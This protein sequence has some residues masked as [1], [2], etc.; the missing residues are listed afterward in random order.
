MR[1]G[2]EGCRCQIE[3]TAEFC[4]GHCREYSEDP[5]HGAHACDCGHPACTAAATEEGEERTTRNLQ[6]AFE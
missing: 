3:E 1:C 6:E 2:H 4:S 5:G